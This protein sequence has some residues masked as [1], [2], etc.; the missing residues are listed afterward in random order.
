MG[1]TAVASPLSARARAL[2]PSPTMAFDGRAKALVAEGRDL[3]NLTAGEPDFDTGPAAS[4]AAIAAIREGFTHYTAAAGVASLRAAIAGKLARENGIRYAPEE[5][6]V[7]TGAK[8]ALYAAMQVLCDPGDEVLVPAPYWVSY[9]EQARL[10]G[11]VPVFVPTREDD[12]FVLRAEAVRRH[13]TPR[14]RLLVLNSPNN[15]TGAVI[16]PEEI[17]SIAEVV[18]AH[19]RLHVISDEIYERMVY[20]GARHA[21][22]AALGPE[23]RRRTVTVNGF[24]KAYAMTGWR[25]GYAAA[26]RPVASAIA[27]FLSQTTSNVTS[28]AQRAAEGALAGDPAAVEAMV[29]EFTA[30]RRYV[31]GR[32]AAMPDLRLPPPGGAFYV[33]PNVSAA[34]GRRSAGGAE[35][36]DVEA[37]ALRLMEEGGLATVPGSGFG[38]TEHIRLSYAAALPMLRTGLDRLEAFLRGLRAPG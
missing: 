17:A 21:S 13:L 38:T 7:T 34:L 27:A 31:L 32:L 30:R 8:F 16:P 10:A 2:A 14:S 3:I 5:I 25:L 28:V 1:A 20:D 23:L 24:S 18:L 33:F 11:A 12:G 26:D 15:P 6:A 19:P 22:I 9:P 4:E 35:L 29:A 37:F 36:P